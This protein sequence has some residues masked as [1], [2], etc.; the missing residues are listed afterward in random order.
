M[1]ILLTGGA[2]FIGS[3]LLDALLQR[4]QDVV[5]VDDFNDYYDP[6]IKRGNLEDAAAR[7]V[8][9]DIRDRGTMDA[10]F[11][12]EAP[13]LVAHLAARAG[14]RPSLENPALYADVNIGGTLKLLELCR[15]HGVPRFLLASSS[16]VYGNARVPFSESEGA[17]EPVS[18]YGATKLAAE[19]YARVYARLHRIRVT[20]LRFFTVYGP[21]Q[22]PDMAIH[23]FA[24]RIADGNPISIFGDGGTER[25]Y[26]YVGD[27][28]DGV[29]RALER[30]E[31]NAV[32]NLGG[33]RPVVLRGLI[34]VL[35]KALGKKAVLRHEREQPGDARA[36]CADITR[37][38]E[39]LGYS[40]R[41]PLEEGIAR[42]VEWFRRSAGRS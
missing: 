39:D 28:V 23:R 31:A 8:E 5:V 14:V 33:S 9:A 10:L 18:P 17:L 7:V 41:V 24:R 4:G 36:T 25:D 3:H 21:R 40:P 19:H 6:R 1:K 16:S 29:M 35:E 34:G 22:R 26:T 12:R 30:D 13:A 2:G 37:A 15:A 20:C 11:R 42:F 27:I 32:Y 38:R